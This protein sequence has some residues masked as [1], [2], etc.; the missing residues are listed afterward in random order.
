MEILGGGVGD[1]GL[2]GVGGD[3]AVGGLGGDG[4]FGEIGGLLER[5]EDGVGDE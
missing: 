4:G 1:G 2:G 5:E 3:S